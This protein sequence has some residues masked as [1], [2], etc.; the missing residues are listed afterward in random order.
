MRE[1]KRQGQALNKL[2]QRGDVEVDDEERI[3]E[4]LAGQGLAFQRHSPVSDFE[5]SEVC[6]FATT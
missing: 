1:A 5:F 2:A 6:A 4:M 3:V